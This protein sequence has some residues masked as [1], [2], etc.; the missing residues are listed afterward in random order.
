[1]ILLPHTNI[2]VTVAK[3]HLAVSAPLSIQQLSLVDVS[4]V[5]LQDTNRADSLLFLSLIGKI[6]GVL[7]LEL[8]KILLIHVNSALR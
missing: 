8:E 4:G 7:D 5:I 2:F 6:L 1:M 3:G